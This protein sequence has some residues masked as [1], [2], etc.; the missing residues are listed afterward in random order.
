MAEN[1][2]EKEQKFSV[3]LLSTKINKIICL[4]SATC[5]LLMIPVL[6]NSNMWVKCC[7]R[8][9]SHS[10][11]G[12]G[13]G[14]QQ[15]RF[16]SIRKAHLTNINPFLK[17]MVF[18]ANMLILFSNRSSL[19]SPV[20]HG[21]WYGALA[22]GPSPGPAHLALPSLGHGSHWTRRIDCP[23]HQPHQTRPYTPGH[24]V[25]GPQLSAPV[26]LPQCLMVPF[27]EGKHQRQ[28]E[29]IG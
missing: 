27:K 9:G 12:I 15:R 17:F 19:F 26:P 25:K 23:S 16:P 29:A 13:D 7:K 3:P 5:N 11:S 22:E 20:Q 14:S 21:P 28:S 10:R 6:D 2:P 18:R 1:E 8:V 24:A 4:K